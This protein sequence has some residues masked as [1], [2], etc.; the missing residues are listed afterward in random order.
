MRTKAQ[1]VNALKN[2]QGWC[3]DDKL[4]QIYM[5]VYFTRPTLGIEIGVFGGKSLFAA[6]M[7]MNDSTG[8]PLYGVDPWAPYVQEGKDTDPRDWEALYQS[9]LKNRDR[10]KLHR[11]SL[12]RETSKAFHA[13]KYYTDYLHIDGN[14]SYEAAKDDMRRWIP[15]CTNGATVIIDDLMWPGVKKAFDEMAKDVLVPHIIREN[16]GIFRKVT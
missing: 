4:W 12:C 1:V 15:Q 7:A 16:W 8:A 9:V 5:Y 14:H 13:R 11:I 10:L 3:D 6:G 2:V